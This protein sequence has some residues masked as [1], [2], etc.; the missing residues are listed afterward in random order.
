V[1]IPFIPI[2]ADLP[3]DESSERRLKKLLGAGGS[4]VFLSWGAHLRW[5]KLGLRTMH[6][7]GGVCLRSERRMAA[8]PECKVIFYSGSLDR[9]GGIDC[10]LSA[11]AL[12]PDPSLRLWVC[13][14]G[15]THSVVNAAARDPRIVFHGC[16][17]EGEL[18]ALAE[19]AY[20]MVNPR[21]P[22]LSDSDNNFPSKVLEY[23]AYGA[24][25]VSTWTGGLSP[26][27]R[28]LMVISDDGSPAA[29]AN[30]LSKVVRWTLEAREDFVVRIRSRLQDGKS[31][32]AQAQRL[33]QFI[34]PLSR[35]R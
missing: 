6:L 20:V 10:L 29:L 25:I 3:G 14:K 17:P 12:L 27:Y 26:E 33:M 23:L 24:P 16:V 19:Q 5:E 18:Q 13:G 22:G 15:P 35:A 9:Y 30:A 32:I 8:K 21:P 7:D 34:E 28:Q 31:W 1:G 4:A 11:F 2:I